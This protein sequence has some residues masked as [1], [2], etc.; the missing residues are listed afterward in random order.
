VRLC[1]RGSIEKRDFYVRSEIHVVTAR[2]DL[3]ASNVKKQKN[4][5]QK[6]AKPSLLTFSSIVGYRFGFIFM[7]V[8]LKRR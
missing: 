5:I 7:L 6:L 2:H 8:T 3:A 1:D 4:Y